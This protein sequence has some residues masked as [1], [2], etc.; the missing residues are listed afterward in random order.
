MKNQKPLTFLRHRSSAVLATALAAL[1]VLPGCSWIGGR[2]PGPVYVAGPDVV[3]SNLR[4]AVLTFR[5]LSSNSFAGEAVSEFIATELYAREYFQIIEPTEV[6]V[7]LARMGLKGDSIG[8][9]ATA[10]EIARKLGV[11]A[12]LYGSVAE[13]AYSYSLREEP[14]VSMALRLVAADSGKVLWAASGAEIGGGLLMQDSVSA[15]AIRLIG[16]LAED[17]GEARSRVTGSIRRPAAS[18]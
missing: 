16:R 1:L 12:V 17:L 7:Q 13:F 8:D 5:N 4:V 11:D 9:A 3:T 15:T 18:E 10:R 6:S 2:D 14:A